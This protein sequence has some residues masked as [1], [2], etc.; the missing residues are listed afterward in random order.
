MGYCATLRNRYLNGPAMTHSNQLILNQ[1]AYCFAEPGRVYAIYLPSGGTTKLNLANYKGR[2]SVQW[3]N[4]RA[5][6]RLQVGSI[7]EIVGPGLITIGQPPK[8]SDKDWA[9]LIKLK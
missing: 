4:P 3:Y 7:K 5:G 6:G 2:F 1:D 9:V 8:D